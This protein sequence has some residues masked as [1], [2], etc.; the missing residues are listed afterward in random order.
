[1]TKHANN[2]D[3]LQMVELPQTTTVEIPLPILEAFATSPI[4]IRPPPWEEDRP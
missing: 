3:R 4:F 2:S 1:M